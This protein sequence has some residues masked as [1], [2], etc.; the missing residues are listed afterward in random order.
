MCE[1]LYEREGFVLVSTNCELTWLTVV[2]YTISLS[3]FMW[4][5]MPG[6]FPAMIMLSE[7]LI[8]WD[9]I[10]WS[11]V[12]IYTHCGGTALVRN[13]Q[14]MNSISTEPRTSNPQCVSVTKWSDSQKFRLSSQHTS[15]PLLSLPFFR[16]ALS[17]SLPVSSYFFSQFV[18]L[19]FSSVCL[20]LEHL[21]LI[22]LSKCFSIK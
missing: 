8:S 4:R 19:S 16:V 7:I 11:L 6:S 21:N 15:L 17:P 20:P 5:Q 2:L 13:I 10:P 12:N 22:C 3:R 1:T 18:F 14:N 9:V